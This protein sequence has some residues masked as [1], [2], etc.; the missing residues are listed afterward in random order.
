[1]GKELRDAIRIIMRFA[2]Y[3]RVHGIRLTDA[4]WEAYA[5]LERATRG[6]LPG[7]R[8]MEDPPITRSDGRRMDNPGEVRR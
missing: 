2:Q 3:A 1:M 6:T 5:V 7:D 8:E 4:E